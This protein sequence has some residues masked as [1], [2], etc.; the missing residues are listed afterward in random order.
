MFSKVWRKDRYKSLLKVLVWSFVKLIQS[1]FVSFIIAFILVHQTPLLRGSAFLDP[2]KKDFHMFDENRSKINKPIKKIRFD[3]KSEPIDVVIPAIEKDLY[4]LELCI[5]GIKKNGEN[6]RNVY[7]V[8]RRKLTENA[9]WVDENSYPFTIKDVAKNLFDSEEKLNM[10]LE[11]GTQRIGWYFQQLLKLYSPVVVPH[12]SSNV[13]VLDSDTI[14]INPVSFMNEL[15]EPLFCPGGCT[16]DSYFNHARNLIPGFI[17]Y[18]NKIAGITHHMLFQKA[19]IKHFLNVIEKYH[20]KPAWKALCNCVISDNPK[21]KKFYLGMSEFEL[22]FN[23][24]LT[25]SNQGHLRPL[26]WIEVPTYHK[27]EYYRSAKYH[28]ISCHSY[29]RDRGGYENGAA[30]L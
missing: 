23:Y 13:L 19:V 6:I 22:Y 28:F 15:N 29:L 20:Q 10:Y 8:S 30:H 12:I 1:Q 25:K 21:S 11:N 26:K 3:L 4:T 2:S 5:E 24:F 17:R 18:D 27:L 7:V 16:S 14:F 9:I